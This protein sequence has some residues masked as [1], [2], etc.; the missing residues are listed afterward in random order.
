MPK[1]DKKEP[2]CNCNDNVTMNYCEKHSPAE[3]KDFDD[4]YK[5]RYLAELNL[6]SQ[7][8]HSLK[9]CKA[10]CDCGYCK[11]RISEMLS[12][13]RTEEREK[14]IA[15]ENIWQREKEDDDLIKD[16]VAEYK[17]ELVKLLAG[18][19]EIHTSHEE[20]TTEAVKDGY[21]QALDDII[22]LI[23]PNKE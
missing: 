16:A 11:N 1:E 15:P 5:K 4:W 3:V 18:K 20:E 14:C 9:W 19:K 13:A 6:A 23:S 21:N 7:E 8:E 12:L 2:Y 17:A 22:N 10:L